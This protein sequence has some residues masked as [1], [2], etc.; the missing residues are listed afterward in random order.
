MIKTIF[1][2]VMAIAIGVPPVPQSSEANPYNDLT[3]SAILDRMSEMVRNMRTLQASLSQEKF[4]AQLGIKD[5]VERGRLYVKRK[6]DRNTYVRVEIQIP[7]K[8]IITVKDNHFV[9]Y[10]PKINQVIEGKVD[11]YAN[12]AAAGFLAYLF[13]GVSQAREEYHITSMGNEL[14]EGHWV[15]HLLLTPKSNTKGLYRQVD[16]WVDH[17]LWLPTVQKFIEANR[18]ETTLKLAEIKLNVPLPE[19]IFTQ[20][21]PANAQRVKG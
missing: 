8:R 11:Q 6:G 10:Q 20:K 14:I 7:D 1:I 5:P 13:G 21:I 18:D 17:Q 19:S 3:V 9:F 16:L 4:Y 15:S 12:R 2:P